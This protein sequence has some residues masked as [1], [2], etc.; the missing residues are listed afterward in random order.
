M[1]IQLDPKSTRHRAAKGIVGLALVIFGL[2]CL[3]LFNLATAEKVTRMPFAQVTLHVAQRG[4]FTDTLA[5]RAVAI[6]RESVIIASERG[7][8]V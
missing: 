8:T 4:T 6:P 1:D 5:T 7:G 2:L 3:W